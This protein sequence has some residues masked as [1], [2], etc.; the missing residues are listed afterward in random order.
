MIESYQKDTLLS[1]NIVWNLTALNVIHDLFKFNNSYTAMFMQ[2][3]GVNIYIKLQR[4]E[5]MTYKF[6]YLYF[7]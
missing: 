4:Q 7:N 6:L 3:Y 5:E 1:F 2:Y